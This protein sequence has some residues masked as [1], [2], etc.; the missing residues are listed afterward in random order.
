MNKQGET[1]LTIEPRTMPARPSLEE[2]F[3]YVSD[4]FDWASG[5]CT[6]WVSGAMGE[7][8]VSS[9]PAWVPR[10]RRTILIRTLDPR[11]RLRGPLPVVL[12]EWDLADHVTAWSYDFDEYGVGQ[13]E[14]SALDDFRAAIASLYF[15]LKEHQDRLGPLPARQWA[16]LQALVTEA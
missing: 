2:G 5:R 10:S 4:T 15:T 16:E 6:V 12:E 13:D 1:L 7:L 11:L 14:Q 9:Y 8:L 3:S